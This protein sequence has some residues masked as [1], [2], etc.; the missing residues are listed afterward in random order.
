MA[1]CTSP[2][3]FALSEKW[4]D[5]PSLVDLWAQVQSQGLGMNMTGAPVTK[6]F[7]K[8]VCEWL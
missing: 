8:Q 2:V 7:G 1:S 4:P 6:K 5:L 3:Q